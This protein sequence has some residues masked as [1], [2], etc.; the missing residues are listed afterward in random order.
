MSIQQLTERVK[1][2]ETEN[3]TLREENTQLKKR[4]SDLERKKNKYVA[5][6]SR[7]EPKA[8]PQKPGR[9][10]GQGKF[11]YRQLPETSAD[12]ITVDIPNHCPACHFTGELRLSHFE[13]ASITELP[14]EMRGEVTIYNVPVL[15][16]PQCG[17]KVRGEH[18]DLATGQC[19][20]TAHR[21]GRRLAAVIQ[22]L[23]HE[24]GVPE[25][26]IPRLLEMTVGL[27]LTQGAINQAAERLAREGG[28]LANHV[29]ELENSIRK[30]TYVHHDD[31]G[32]RMGGKQAWVSAYRSADTAL[33]KANPQH[34]AKELHAVLK[35]NFKGTLVCDR[36]KVYDAE[37]FAEVSQQKCMSHVIRNIADVAEQLKGRP[38]RGLAYVQ[39]LKET[40]QMALK[41]HKDFQEGKITERQ[42]RYRG[43][44]V[45]NRVTR[46]LIRTDIRT[47]E[48]ERLRAGLQKQHERGRL[49]LFLERPEIPPTN[50]AA[51]RQLR[52][53]VMAR[54][55]SQCSKNPRGATT[56]MRIKSVTETA[57][58]R[59]HDPVD[60]LMALAR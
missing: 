52:S 48:S 38:G 32:W 24:L 34:T 55:I 17:Q 2:L 10:A 40:F 26:K 50:N 30:A 18:P 27:S 4:I 3:K 37:L 57:R 14:K 22:T 60:T 16:C 33:F 12:E 13:K 5:P 45:R 41:V 11:S 25:R 42:F 19:G 59:G 23:H 9:K 20:A 21:L 49:L 36:F 54:K 28:P 35:D 1:D 31:T 6:H 39:C 47:K 7:E 58:L 44:L 46:L 29:L 56:Y 15:F 8:N 53:V 51:E 43:G